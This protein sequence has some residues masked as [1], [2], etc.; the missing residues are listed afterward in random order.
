MQNQRGPQQNQGDR[1]GTNRN[2]NAARGGTVKADAMAVFLEDEEEVQADMY[3]AL[4]SSGR[5]TQFS[6][7]ETPLEFEGKFFHC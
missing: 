4:D 5:N 2:V 6:V 1:T 7:I 3:A